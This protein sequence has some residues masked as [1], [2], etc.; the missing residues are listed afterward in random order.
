MERTRR[1]LF[2]LET[3]G[4]LSTPWAPRK[5]HVS[6]WHCAVVI[7]LDTEEEF[8]FTA[9][10]GFPPLRK[11]LDSAK[12]LAGHNIVDYDL[13]V[14]DQ[15]FDWRPHYSVDLFD[16]R[17]AGEM[18]YSA[19]RL[20]LFNR[21][22]EQRWGPPPDGFRSGHSLGLWAWRIGEAKGDFGKSTDW[23][24]YSPE[25]LEYCAT[26]VRVNVALWKYFLGARCGYSEA[27]FVL[28]CNVAHVLRRQRMNGVGFDVTKARALENVLA[29]R[30][31]ELA[32]QLRREFP[33]WLTSGGTATP[34]RSQNRTHEELI[35]GQA[36]VVDRMEKGKPY[37]RVKHVELNPGSRQ[38]VAYCLTQRYG[39]KPAS[40]NKDGSPKLDRK[41][42]MDLPWELAHDFA[43]YE[44][45]N[46]K[47]GMVST[48]N[49]GWMKHE[50]KGIIRGR[51]NV[52]G[53]KTGRM[54]HTT[55][56][57]GQVP[58]VGKP[59]GKE[60]RECFGPTRAGWVQ[61]GADASGLEMRMF[62]H[63]LAAWD[64]GDFARV[65]LNGDIHEY[66]RDATGLYIRNNQKTFSYAWLY[67]AQDPKLGAIVHFDWSMAYEQGLVPD[68][69]PRLTKE[70]ARALG[71]RA[72]GRLLSKIDAIGELTE[73]VQSKK[74]D[75]GYVL[76]PDGRRVDIESKHSAL[77]M[78]L[79]GAGAIVMKRAQTILDHSLQGEGMKPGKDY[80]FM[81]TVHDEWQLECP[82]QNAEFVGRMACASIT[83]AGEAYNMNIPLA[84]EYK[85][86]AN[87]AET[88]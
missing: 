47:L 50:K 1:L 84:G 80:E 10:A 26:D 28:D 49:E 33:P 88:H 46:K 59:Y 72:R 56:N 44:E 57:L 38:H 68:A 27:S 37:L 60:C 65:V 79:Q 77:N 30:R 12:Y 78:L 17:L 75:P 7:D 14:L 3:D 58:S 45:L 5:D 18:A 67:G 15:L 85:V 63:Y 41:L 54:S 73:L 20:F 61:V 43:E 74:D 32:V 66:F 34:K 55:P 11:L 83:L 35:D 25:M 2:D 81:L 48:G 13:P 76:L 16:T 36:V 22:A 53:T 71:K 29:T 9:D 24:V 39:W 82:A 87:W 51:V 4:L 8:R 62:A 64:H 69:P 19:E 86:G 23:K 31:D 42:L 6:K 52:S 21:V 70:S 40:Y